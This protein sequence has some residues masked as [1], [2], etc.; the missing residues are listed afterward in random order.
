MWKLKKDIKNDYEESGRGEVMK[1]GLEKSPMT[2][3]SMP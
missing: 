1:E 3:T 2:G